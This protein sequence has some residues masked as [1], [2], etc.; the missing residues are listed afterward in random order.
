MALAI[1][2]GVVLAITDLRATVAG[3]APIPFW[4]QWSTVAEYAAARAHGLSW[5][6]L[7]SQSN[8]HRILFPRLVMFADMAWLHGRNRLSYAGI[9]LCQA[10]LVTFLIAVAARLANRR[11]ALLSLGL[12][13]ALLFSQ[14]QWENLIWAFQVQFFM[15]VAAGVW[16]IH[17]FLRAF[18]T[19]GRTDYRAWAGSLLHLT[20]AS[21]SMANGLIAGAAA[22]AVGVLARRPWR[23]LAVQA[24]ALVVLAIVYFHGYQAA[25]DSG[26]VAGALHNPALYLAFIAT[27]LGNVLRGAGP[28]AA[29]WLGGLGIVASLAAAARLALGA[30]R[31]PGRASL[32]GVMAFVVASAMVTGLGRM[33]F[34]AEQGLVSRYVTPTAVFWAVQ[35]LYWLSLLPLRRGAGLLPVAAGLALVIWPMAVLEAHE[36]GDLVAR[37]QQ[38]RA[39]ALALELG[40]DDPAALQGLTWNVPAMQALVPFLQQE[41]LSIF[42]TPPRF[43]NG[44]LTVPAVKLDSG[45]VGALD[46]LGR[47]PGDAAFHAEGWGWDA[48]RRRPLSDVVLADD[49]GHIVA[50]AVSGGPRDDVPAALPKVRSRYT[51]WRAVLAKPVPSL[52]AYGLLDKGRLCRLGRKGADNAALGAPAA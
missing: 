46:I 29:L 8:E 52:T 44:V 15:V 35:A 28:Q 3:F 22:I 43:S 37:A 31:E 49:S 34:G 11:A 12:G 16:S 24:A 21:F 41:R 7:S 4:D 19:P 36:H 47:L 9:L 51:G 39:G 2:P 14:A 30:D 42:S 50:L 5:G 48:R 25:P 6:L 23:G 10:S 20:V 33:A 38:V 40:L 27:Y 13:A 1:V 32:V 17:L 45:C 18:E 26:G